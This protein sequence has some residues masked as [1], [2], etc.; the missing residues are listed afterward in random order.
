[1]KNK[2]RPRKSSSRPRA[3]LKHQ[4]SSGKQRWWLRSKP[5]LVFLVTLIGLILAIPSNLPRVTAVYDG[6][7]N[8]ENSPAFLV[9]NDGVLGLNNVHLVCEYTKI[10]YVRHDLHANNNTSSFRTT[11]GR[12]PPDGEALALCPVPV[13]ILGAE[14]LRAEL[15]LHVTYRPDFSFIPTSSDIT[16]TSLHDLLHWTPPQL[17]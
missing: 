15:I 7:N 2:Q 16:F 8:I 17:F 1:M 3:P 9:R 4:Q 14:I 13:I 5:V 12:I 10:E 6:G 11:L